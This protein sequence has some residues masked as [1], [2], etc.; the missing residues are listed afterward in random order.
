MTRPIRIVVSSV[1]TRIA[2]ERLRNGLEPSDEIVT[3]DGATRPATLEL[4]DVVLHE[5]FDNELETLGGILAAAPRVRWI[6]SLAAGIDGLDL[7]ELVG[8]DVLFTNSAGIFAPGMAEYVVAGLVWAAR[9]L[10]RWQQSARRDDSAP[11]GWELRGRRV[12]I[13][14]YGGVGR[15]VAITCRAL[16][17]E[18]WVTRRTPIVPALEPIDRAV[19][20]AEFSDMLASCDALVLCSSL[21]S[22]TRQLLDAE[23]FARVRHGAVLVNVARGGL[24]DQ[25]ALVDALRSGRVSGAVLDVTTP[26]P[27]PEDHPLRSIPNTYITPHVSG[28]T[29]EAWSR[30]I[31]LFL[32]NLQLYRSGRARFLA[33]L[34]DP[35][36]HL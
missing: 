28:D 7:N 20:A 4:A 22:S 6:H 15:M 21:N 29:E 8:R 13:V 17:M 33:N 36:H 5:Y 9:G 24:V 11:I 14:G 2:G 23:A 30:K 35:A 31:D 18:V 19:D 25:D 3:V 16:G 32:A 27:L 10:G 26:E 1:V 12:G 34:V